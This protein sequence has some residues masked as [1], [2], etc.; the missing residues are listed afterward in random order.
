MPLR[1]FQ[2]RSKPGID[3]KRTVFHNT[4]LPRVF[5][6]YLEPGFRV[7]K[8]GDAAIYGAFPSAHLFLLP[9]MDIYIRGSQGFWHFNPTL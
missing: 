5:A 4:A 9:D 7:A 8:R 1:S 3:R 6:D 2:G